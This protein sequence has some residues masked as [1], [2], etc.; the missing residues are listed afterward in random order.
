MLVL[1]GVLA[2]VRRRLYRR[3]PYDLEK[4]GHYLRVLG[5][6]EPLG[7]GNRTPLLDVR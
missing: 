4:Q 7:P 6:G 2:G 3:P 5:G 1:G